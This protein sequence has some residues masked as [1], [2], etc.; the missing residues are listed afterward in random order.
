MSILE[1]INSIFASIRSGLSKTLDFIIK[2]K[3][4]LWVA[5]VV[6]ISLFLMSQCK[7]N[8]EL[9]REVD[10]LTNNSYAL[11]DSL[12]HYHDKLGNVSAEKQPPHYGC[13]QYRRRR[14]LSYLN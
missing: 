8:N 6:V 9:D 5:V 7:S 4:I 12:Q 10:R 1:K 11:T 2:I 3:D 13:W 14:R